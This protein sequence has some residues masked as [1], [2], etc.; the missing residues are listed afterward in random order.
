MKKILVLMTLI[1]A[2]AM[3]LSAQSD[4]NYAVVGDCFAATSQEAYSECARYASRKDE[5]SIRAMIAKGT[6]VVMTKGTNVQLKKSNIITTT[7][8][9]LDG[10]HKG[11]TIVLSPSDIRKK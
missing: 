6:V 1:V 4:M 5:A 2:F 8:V 9:V 3:R 10:T 11:K 7:V